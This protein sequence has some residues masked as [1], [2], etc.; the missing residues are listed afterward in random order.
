MRVFIEVTEAQHAELK[1]QAGL[2]PLSRWIRS[3]LFPVSDEA[4]A[5]ELIPLLQKSIKRSK[6]V[7]KKGEAVWGG[8]KV[9]A[10]TE[11]QIEEWAKNLYPAPVDMSKIL[12]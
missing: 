7:I 12:P 3:Q 10:M 2:I 4:R 6:K 5:K 1:R 11:K 8:D 9:P